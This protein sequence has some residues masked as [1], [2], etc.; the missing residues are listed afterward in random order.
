MGLNKGYYTFYAEGPSPNNPDRI[1]KTPVCVLQ[2]LRD[3]QK[4]FCGAI[5]HAE[6]AFRC[7]GA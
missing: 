1:I 7:Q 4:R 2:V 5:N 6:P 3:D